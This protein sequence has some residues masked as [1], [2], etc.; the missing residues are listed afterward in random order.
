[1]SRL[2]YRNLMLFCLMFSTSALALYLR[3]NEKIAERLPNIDLP[4]LVPTRFGEWW[5]LKNKG[6]LIIDS[7]QQQVLERIYSQTLTRTY[8]NRDGELIMLSIA[9]G[10]DQRDGLQLHKPEVCYPAQGF[11]V[12]QKQAGSLQLN[13]ELPTIP[14]T[15]LQTVLGSRHEPVTYWTTVGD[16]AYTGMFEKKLSEMRYGLAGKIPDGML[17]RISSIDAR[18]ERA[19]ELHARFASAL[20]EALP[21]THKQR[22]TGIKTNSTHGN[23]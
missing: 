18:A 20:Y 3:P 1:M 7:G 5:E 23:E 10:E 16:R 11:Q 21:D 2:A 4:Q 22:F 13:G 17:V 9:Y 14:V 19:Y 6:I 12:R 15:R 8:Q